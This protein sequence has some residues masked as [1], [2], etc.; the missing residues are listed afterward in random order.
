MLESFVKKYI[1][2]RDSLRKCRTQATDSKVAKSL[3]NMLEI[4]MEIYH[5][6]RRSKN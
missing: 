1:E 6:V 3:D 2:I 4:F 5:D